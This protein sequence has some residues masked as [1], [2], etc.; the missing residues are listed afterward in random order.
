MMELF[1]NQDVD[2]QLSSLRAELHI[3]MAGVRTDMIDRLARVR[4]DMATGFAGIEADLADVKAEMRELAADT[5]AI[6][7]EGQARS[8]RAMRF[9][10]IWIIATMISI[11]G[12]AIAVLS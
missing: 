5:H 6:I 10:I 4:T 7:A 3:E 11:T 8:E 1:S 9:Q 2:A 12:I